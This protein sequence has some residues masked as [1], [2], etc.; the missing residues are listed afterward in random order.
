MEWV[1]GAADV[2]L[3]VERDGAAGG[4]DGG[5]ED[6]VV[7]A[8]DELRAKAEVAAEGKPIEC[9]VAGTEMEVDA[10]VGALLLKVGGVAEEVGAGADVELCCERCGDV[11]AGAGEAYAGGESKGGEGAIVSSNAEGWWREGDEGGWGSVRFA[12]N[13]VERCGVERGVFDRCGLREGVGSGEDDR[14]DGDAE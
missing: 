11:E 14:G 9:G 2:V 12:G 5:G 1:G 3:A 8:E 10:D 7:V 13:C 4:D 6:A